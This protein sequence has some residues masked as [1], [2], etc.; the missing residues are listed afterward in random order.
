[1]HSF[2]QTL[3]LTF[4][5][6]TVSTLNPTVGI[7]VTDWFSLSLYNIAAH[8]KIRGVFF[9]TRRT[10]ALWLVGPGERERL[11]VLPAASRPSMSMRISLLPKRLAAIFE[12]MPPIFFVSFLSEIFEKENL[13][14]ERE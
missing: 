11:L 1:M 10:G 3:N 13:Q 4:L 7:V 9:S 12:N 2:T 14:K 5:Y 6:V 8:K